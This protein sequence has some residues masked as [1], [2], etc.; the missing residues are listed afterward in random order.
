MKSAYDRVVTQT[1]VDD[2]LWRLEHLMVLHGLSARDWSEK[3]GMSES[4]L[5][6]AIGRLRSSEDPDIQLGTLTKLANFVKV[7]PEWLAFGK[8]VRK[9]DPKYPQRSGAIA[10]AEAQKL[11][12][13]AI[14]EVEA[15]DPGTDFDHLTWWQHL[16]AAAERARLA[17]SRMSPRNKN[18]V[19]RR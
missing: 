9:I 5:N 16:E 14:A 18:R 12:S 4:T 1:E 10:M 8:G 3:A 6:R 7:P 19:H 15:M 13:A 2:L 17:E 11:P